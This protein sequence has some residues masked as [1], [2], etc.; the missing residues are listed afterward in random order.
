VS[1]RI[2]LALV[3][4]A[5]GLAAGAAVVGITL[6]TRD[7]PPR[8]H[9]QPGMPPVPQRLPGPAGAAVRQAFVD[10]PHG[11]LAALER[12]GQEYPKSPVVQLYR[13][14]GLLWAGYTGDAEVV[15]RR[16]KRV[17]RDTPWELAA[18][19]VLHPQYFTGY[20]V[21]T[22]T[23]PNAL[24]ERG[25]RLQAQGHQHAAER[26]YQRAARIA[27]DDDEAQVAA[28]VGRF[29]KDDL[30]ASFSRLGP[31]AQRFPK[32][33]AVRFYLGL[34]LAWTDQRDQAVAEFEKAIALGPTTTLG[35]SAKAFVDRVGSNTTDGR[36]K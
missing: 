26:L 13:G 5:V 9:A 33:Q 15:L 34:M 4:A 32:S 19:N 18:D 10:W 6:A 27:P 23:R 12:L 1:Q 14:I 30:S 36:S 29:D 35:R 28:A 21:F 25:S 16:A 8:L 3:V 20:P 17:G 7:T 24:L 31:L 11:S 2:Q 22:P